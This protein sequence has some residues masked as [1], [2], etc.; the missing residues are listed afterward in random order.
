MSCVTEQVELSTG[1]IGRIEGAFGKSG[2]LKVCFTEDMQPSTVQR[3]EA[4]RG[5]KA[6]HVCRLMSE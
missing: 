1:E 3:I 2:K 5:G 6:S 4:R